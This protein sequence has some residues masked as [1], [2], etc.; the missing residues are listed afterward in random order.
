M[1]PDADGVFPLPPFVNLWADR[2]EDGVMRIWLFTLAENPGC[3]DNVVPAHAQSLPV[4]LLAPGAPNLWDCRLILDG[5]DLHPGH[6]YDLRVAFL[7]PREATND[8][9]PG[10]VVGL[11]P[12]GRQGVGTML[13]LSAD[14]L[15]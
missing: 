3:R 2:K 7:S 13:S 8:I 12:Q 1:E 5:Q 4:P 10:T 9:Q 6:Q 11:G 14:L 15:R